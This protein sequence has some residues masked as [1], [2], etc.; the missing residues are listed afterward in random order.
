MVNYKKSNSTLYHNVVIKL[1]NS[2]KHSNGEPLS[3]HELWVLQ[4]RIEEL[5]MS[6]DEESVFKSIPSMVGLLINKEKI[7]AKLYLTK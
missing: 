1:L 6:F 2:F 4:L 7:N 3:S 5:T